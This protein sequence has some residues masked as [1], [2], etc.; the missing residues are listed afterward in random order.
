MRDIELTAP[1]GTEGKD[2][3][4][5]MRFPALVWDRLCFLARRQHRKPVDMVRLYVD[6]GLTRD[7]RPTRRETSENEEVDDVWSD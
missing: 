7:Y 5:S 1:T 4:R 6:E 3:V 2:V